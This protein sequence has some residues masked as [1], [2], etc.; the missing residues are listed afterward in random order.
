[1]GISKDVAIAVG[2]FVAVG[3]MVAAATSSSGAPRTPTSAVAT[4]S[5]TGT[6]Y[7]M[8]VYD[9]KRAEG[10]GEALQ[11]F[12]SMLTRYE[13]GQ[14]TLEEVA[15]WSERVRDARYAS[16]ASAE[17]R[18]RMK[19]LEQAVQKRVTAGTATAI[20]AHAAAYYRAIAE[21]GAP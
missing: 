21:A 2:G 13:N 19:R 6:A 16:N 3:A 20:D 10:A 1:M 4:P 12:D 7:A 8:Q 17:H 5:L 14:A 18:D 11:V 9:Q 15:T